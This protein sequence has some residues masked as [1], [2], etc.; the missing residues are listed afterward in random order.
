[1]AR[2]RK[3]SNPVGSR[4]GFLVAVALTA[5][6]FLA[7]PRAAS[8]SGVCPPPE[9]LSQVI[10]VD[11][12]Y[13]GPL[14]EQFRPIYG[15]YAEG[16]AACWDSQ[17]IELTGYVGHPEG[18]GGTRTWAIEP[19][20]LVSQAHFLSVTDSGA[21]EGWP[22]GPFLPVAVPPA[23]DTRFAGFEGRWVVVTGHFNDKVAKTCVAEGDPAYGP[24]PTTEQAIAICR[25]AFVV[26][27]VKAL[28]APDTDS[29]P[30]VTAA[31]PDPEPSWP[32]IAAVA[33]LAV[34]MFVRIVRR[35]GA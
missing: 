10:S 17:P 25:T 34:A 18:I 8:A 15:V 29:A 5:T 7:A 14:T 26:T 13:P 20:W 22:D 35:A 31:V 3:R 2:E 33:A 21:F 9:S 4:A 27:A 1:M 24:V 23:L 6:A 32:L 16:A 12:T 19:R 28:A 11:A 30:V